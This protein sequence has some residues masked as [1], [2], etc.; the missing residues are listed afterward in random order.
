MYIFISAFPSKDNSKFHSY[1]RPIKFHITFKKNL[2]YRDMFDYDIAY[3][4]YLRTEMLIVFFNCKRISL[5]I[6]F[7]N[8]SFEI[9]N[10]LHNYNLKINWDAILLLLLNK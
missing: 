9:W 4:F 3:S 5:K 10:H 8:L 2:L 7:S 6:K 1:F